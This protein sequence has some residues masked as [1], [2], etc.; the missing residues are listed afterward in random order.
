[1]NFSYNGKTGNAVVQLRSSI[2]FRTFSFQMACLLQPECN[3]LH[4]FFRCRLP[5]EVVDMEVKSCQCR[6]HT[7][8]KEI[9]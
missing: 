3:F 6:A 2:N 8:S 1:M 4:G 5:V 7:S 9:E